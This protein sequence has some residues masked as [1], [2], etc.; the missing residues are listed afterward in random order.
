MSQ[1]IEGLIKWPDKGRKIEKNNDA[2]I[3]FPQELSQK[4]VLFLPPLNVHTIYI[5]SSSGIS[6]DEICCQITK[7][8]TAAL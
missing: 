1:M 6:S 4:T 5:S 7:K 2:N 3:V 8:F